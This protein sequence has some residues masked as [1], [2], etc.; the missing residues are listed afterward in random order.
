MTTHDKARL[1][2]QFLAYRLR[3]EGLT[4]KQIGEQLGVGAQRAR[5]IWAREIWRLTRE[6]HWMDDLSIRAANI[7]NNLNLKSRKEVLEAYNSG[8]LNPSSKCGVR[9]YGWGTHKEIAAWLG[10]PEPMMPVRPVCSQ[11]GQPIKAIP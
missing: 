8:R 2:R 4:F 7:L 11:C 3:E 5:Q 1:A 6:P 9:N 10:L